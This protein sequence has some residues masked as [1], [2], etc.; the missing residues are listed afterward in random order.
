MFRLHDTDRVGALCSPEVFSAHERG[1]INPFTHYGAVWL[2][3]V[4]FFS[5]VLMTTFIESL[6]MLTI[7]STLAPLCLKLADTH[8]PHGFYASLATVGTLSGGLLS[9]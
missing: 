1:P 8:S 4:S 6:H 7:P 2:K 9:P 3:L 5:L